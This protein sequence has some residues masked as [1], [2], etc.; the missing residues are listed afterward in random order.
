MDILAMWKRGSTNKKIRIFFIV[1]K[2]D[3]RKYECEKRV[4]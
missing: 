1:L 4:V 2:F 3:D